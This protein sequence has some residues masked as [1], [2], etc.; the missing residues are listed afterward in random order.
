M[1]SILN[2]NML[3]LFINILPRFNM[4]ELNALFEDVIR[5]IVF[6]ILLVMPSLLFSQQKETIKI[7]INTSYQQFEMTA[8]NERINNP[9]NFGFLSDKALNDIS[10]SSGFKHGLIISYQ[11]S[12]YFSLGFYGSF[13]NGNVIREINYSSELPFEPFFDTVIGERRYKINSI[14]V[15]VSSSFLLHNLNFWQKY[16]SLVKLE[17]AITFQIGYGFANM[18]WY[19]VHKYTV[20]EVLMRKFKSNGLDLGGGLR[21]G[22][23][24]LNDN[25]FSS[26]GFSFG[27]Q[28]FITSNLKSEGGKLFID[29]SNTTTLDFSGFNAGVYLTLGK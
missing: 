23:I 26:I 12:P 28:Y 3:L 10:I 17:S 20:D 6:L 24:L 4:M 27:Y 22:Y 11:T 5:K 9:D 13:Q 1:A 16:P 29:E 18:G 19:D 2:K 14:N 25:L 7:E 15:G 8:F 21:L